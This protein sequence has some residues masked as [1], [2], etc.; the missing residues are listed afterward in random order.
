M[1]KMT[2]LKFDVEGFSGGIESRQ[3]YIPL[4]ASA[5]SRQFH[6]ALDGQSA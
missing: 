6:E 2:S 4:I 5:V 1:L 3:A